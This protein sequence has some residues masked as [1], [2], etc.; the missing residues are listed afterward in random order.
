MINKLFKMSKWSEF[1]ITISDKPEILES[2]T[3]ATPELIH[4]QG[5][6]VHLYASERLLKQMPVFSSNALESKHLILVHDDQQFRSDAI[7][8]VISTFMKCQ[9]QIGMKSRQILPFGTD[10]SRKGLHMFK[11]RLSKFIDG[12]KS[13]NG[14]ETEDIF[15]IMVLNHENDYANVKQVFTS[16]NIM[17]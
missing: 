10:C 9:G 6:D 1:D 14:I 8:N 12:Y 11:E 15:L 3:L 17:S 16:M 7:Q 2:R 13:K 4:K 5:D